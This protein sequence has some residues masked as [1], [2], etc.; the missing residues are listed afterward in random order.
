MIITCISRFRQCKPFWYVNKFVSLEFLPWSWRPRLVKSSLLSFSYHVTSCHVL[1][2]KTFSLQM[3]IILLLICITIALWQ[4]RA[5]LTFG[6]A[7]VVYCCYMTLMEM[8][9]IGSQ[10]SV[11]MPMPMPKNANQSYPIQG[12]YFDFCKSYEQ[13]RRIYLD[14]KAAL[15]CD[16]SRPLLA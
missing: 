3:K 13:W 6:I 15:I 11:E 9:G 8:L 4:R 14:R 7:D 16:P 1:C 2:K 5:T 10:A 12:F